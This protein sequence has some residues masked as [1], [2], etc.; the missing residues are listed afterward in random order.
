MINIG[1]LAGGLGEKWS[2]KACGLITL[3]IRPV[4]HL[5]SR[6]WFTLHFGVVCLLLTAVLECF[7]CNLGH[8]NCPWSAQIAALVFT[9]EKNSLSSSCMSSSVLCAQSLPLCPTVCDPTDWNCQAPLS[10]GFSRQEYW[11]GLPCPPPGDLTD[12][13]MWTR[14]SCVSSPA[15]IL[16]LFKMLFLNWRFIHFGGQDSRVCVH[17]TK[18][19]TLVNLISTALLM[20]SWLLRSSSRRKLWFFLDCKIWVVSVDELESVK[21]HKAG[22][23]LLTASILV[24]W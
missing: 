21:Q 15:S 8:Y 24:C 10:L 22:R 5:I 4:F 20:D 23:S 2:E 13:K 14:I 9:T 7:V 1:R 16:S 17:F 19:P 18:C 12:P 3:Y 6:C 11:S